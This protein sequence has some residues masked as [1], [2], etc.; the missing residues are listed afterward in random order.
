MKKPI[1]LLFAVLMLGSPLTSFA[2]PGHAPD[3]G[4]HRPDHRS[5]QHQPPKPPQGGHHPAR[6][7]HVDPRYYRDPHY[8]PRAGMPVPHRDWRPG[9]AVQPIYRGDRYWVTDWRARHLYAPPRDHRWLH[10][11]GDYVLVAIASGLIVNIL[12]GY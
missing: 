1:A 6:P 10:I 5:Q 2:Q 9:V 4:P 3:N 7:G 11:N 8:R 12:S